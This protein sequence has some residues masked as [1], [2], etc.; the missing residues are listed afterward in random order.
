MVYLR[1]QTWWL[2]FFFSLFLLL[3]GSGRWLRE[4]GAKFGILSGWICCTWCTWVAVLFVPNLVY[5]VARFG[6]LAGVLGVLGLSVLFV[7]RF[8]VYLVDVLWCAL[9]AEFGA[10]VKS[11]FSSFSL[12]FFFGG[13]MGDGYGNL[14]AKFGILSGWI[15]CTWCTWVCCTFCT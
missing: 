6:V 15:C 2:G 7:A 8:G 3:G 14:V 13:G 12:C 9:V 10:Y 4:F 11:L 1:C 5:L